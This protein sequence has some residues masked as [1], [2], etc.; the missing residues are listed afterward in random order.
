MHIGK[1]VLNRDMP[2]LLA[3]LKDRLPA[4]PIDLSCEQWVMLGKLDQQIA[5]IEQQLLAWLQQDQACWMTLSSSL[6]EIHIKMKYG[7]N[8]RRS[9]KNF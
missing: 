2:W 3:K 1:M 6:S 9:S 4:V 7:A 8:G 5:T